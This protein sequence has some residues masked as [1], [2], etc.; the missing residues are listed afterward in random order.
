MYVFLHYISSKAI[1]LG[2]PSSHHPL[3]MISGGNGVLI[4]YVGGDT[5]QGTTTYTTKI[6]LEC[7][8]YTSGVSTI[9][10]T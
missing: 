4:S 9:Y 8:N 5:C 6:I 1:N 10:S 3:V 2:R 7:S